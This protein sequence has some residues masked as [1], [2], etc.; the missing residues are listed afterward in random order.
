MLTMKVFH[1]F[2]IPNG[3]SINV[4]GGREGGERMAIHFVGHW[5]MKA[6]VIML[7]N[8]LVLFESTILYQVY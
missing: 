7:H 2:T 3:S 8:S 1:V 5:R 4:K 6:V